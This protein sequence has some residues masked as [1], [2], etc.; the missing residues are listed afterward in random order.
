M[1]R[2]RYWAIGGLALALAAS[3]AGT[4]GYAW[5]LRGDGYREYCANYLSQALGL[6]SDIGRVVP[7]SW[8]AREFQ[9]VAVWLP[10][11]R[12]KALTCAR[13]IVRYLRDA[14]RPGD[15]EIEMMGG[16]AEIS[17][18][19]WLREDYRHVIESGLRP[20]FDPVGPRRVKFSG[21]DLRFDRERF[22][23]RLDDAGGLVTFDSPEEGRATIWCRALNGSL[24]REPIVTRVRFSP[25]NDGIQLDEVELEVPSLPLAVLNLQELTGIG[26]ARGQFRGN[27]VYSE[28]GGRQFVTL[29]GTCA[30]LNLAEWTAGWAPRPWRG[31]C[32]E[33]ELTEFTVV[34]RQPQRLRFNGVLTGLVLGDVAALWGFQDVGGELTLR[35]RDAELSPAGIERLIAS[36]QCLELSLAAAT[37]A[38][39]RGVMSGR[40]SLVIDDLTITQNRV[41]S[42]DAVLRVEPNQEGRWI[43]GRLV[44]ELL[45]RLL[46]TTLPPLLPDRIEYIELGLRVEIRDEWLYVF[47]THGT[48]ERSILTVRLLGQDWPLLT[49]PDEPLHLRPWLDRVRAAAEAFL[50][51]RSAALPSLPELM[52]PAT[53]PA[54]GRRASD[55]P[56]PPW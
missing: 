8:S 28:A 39:G 45:G 41:E 32:P 36:G 23:G 53:A 54:P 56:P 22:Q 31:A 9:D 47:G 1:Q 7:R 33:L 34:D 24:S 25:L 15:Y 55:E 38:L 3:L 30:D 51:R 16:T 26:A 12:G 35:V 40:A 27:L 11:R 20:G 44:T 14:Q 19:T 29:R 4:G 42:L 17:T 13:A 46:R 50:R 2:L 37:R 49:Q 5:Y 48:G 10:Q 18:R 6:P 52:H 43:E 21:M